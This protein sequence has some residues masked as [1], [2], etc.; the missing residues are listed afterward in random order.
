MT[1]ERAIIFLER[2]ISEIDALPQG[3]DENAVFQKWRLTTI[4]V[5]ERVFGQGSRQLDHF[6]KIIF[7][8]TVISAND[9]LHADQRKR[10]AMG[11][12]IRA[13]KASLEAYL[14]EFV[15][16]GDDDKDGLKSNP[17][18]RVEQICNRFHR[19]ARQMRSRHSNRETL[20][21]Q[22]EYDVQDLMHSLLMLD[23]DD[24]RAEEWTP[25]YAGSAS[26]MDFLLKQESTVIEVKKSRSTL[27][28]KELGEELLVDT[29]RYECHPDCKTLVCFVYDPEGLIANPA[30]LSNDL[31]KQYHKMNVRVFIKPD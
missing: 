10:E 6:S 22:D 31:E 13:A 28:A 1:K 17:L 11:R 12:G 25:S 26:R 3:T 30:G 20:N 2:A 4:S 8:R 5:L 9:P 16:F 7:H 27:R 15:E 18:K 29:A 19:I 14:Q 23:F 24:I 21:V